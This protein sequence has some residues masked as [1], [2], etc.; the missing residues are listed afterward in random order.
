MYIV[1]VICSEFLW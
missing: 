1:L